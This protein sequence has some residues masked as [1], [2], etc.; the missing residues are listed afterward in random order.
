MRCTAEEGGK[1]RGRKPLNSEF[2]IS[3]RWGINDGEVALAGD[4]T[5]RSGPVPERMQAAS[6]QRTFKQETEV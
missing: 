5:L 1:G 4:L 6:G 2:R 3:L